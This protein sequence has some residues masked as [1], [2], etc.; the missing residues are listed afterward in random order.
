MA[1]RSDGV[2]LWDSGTWTAGPS[3]LQVQDD[4]NVVLYRADGSASWSTGWD[5]GG[6]ATSP[7]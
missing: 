3:R 5:G 2:A 7:N 1:Y 6:V 4:G